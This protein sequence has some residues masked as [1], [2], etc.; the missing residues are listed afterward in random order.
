MSLAERRLGRVVLLAPPVPGV[1]FTTRLG[2]A[3]SPPFASLNLGY[4]TGDSPACVTLN[5]GLVSRAL[6]VCSRWATVSQVH[7]ADVV[8]AGPDGQGRTGP[9]RA[10]AVVTACRSF[11]LAVL[12]ADCV[13]IA[14]VAPGCVGAVHAGWRGLCAGVV[15]S[16]VAAMSQAVAAAPEDHDARPTRRCPSGVQAWIGPSIGPCHYEVGPDVPRRFGQSH[17]NA[18]DFTR[19]TEGVVRF[20]L[21]EAARWLLT[22]A[23]ATVLNVDD[24][25]CTWCDPRFYSHRR[26]GRTGR[27]ALLVWGE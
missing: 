6:G 14:L 27:H 4:S 8:V 21:R 2:G 3:S 5:R 25:P 9:R 11:P 16:A 12:A 1:A 17:P 7:G 23:G 24:P 13:P 20:D 18:P 26:D 22:S 15:E 10:D 19:C